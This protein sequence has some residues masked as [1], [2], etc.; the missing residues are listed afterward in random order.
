MNI[1]AYTTIVRIRSMNMKIDWSE[2]YKRDSSQSIGTGFFIDDKGFILTCSHVVE[3]AVKLL[4]TIP[5]NGNQEFETEVVCIHPELDI[6]LLKTNFKNKDFLKL[7]DSDT[8]Q[9]GQD[10]IALGYPLGQT[11]IKFTKGIVSGLQNSMIQTDTPLNPGNSGGPLL[12]NQGEVIGINTSAIVTAE[13][14]G[15][16]TPIY[17][18]KQLQK[19]FHK[20]SILYLPKMGII[21]ENTTD[22][23][24]DFFDLNSKCDSGVYIKKVFK[25]D[26]NSKS[27]LEEKDIICQFDQ[28]KLDNKGE[29]TVSWS[30]ENVPLR[31]LIKRFKPG[32]KVDITFWNHKTNKYFTEAFKLKG[33]ND[34]FKI[35]NYYPLY[36]KVEYE[37]FAGCIFMNLTNNHLENYE[38]KVSNDILSFVKREKQKEDVLIITH[39]FPSSYTGKELI[40]SPNSVISKVNNK[41]VSNL[42][43]LAKAFRSTIKKGNKE[44]I[45]IELSN[46][47][48]MIYDLEKLLM[49]EIASSKMYNY[50]VTPIGQYFIKKYL[51]K[52]KNKNLILKSKK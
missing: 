26:T 43:N 9:N 50:E 5:S 6:A 7:G 12:N 8:I 4:I 3:H 49:E 48:L 22:T 47:S 51:S 32:Q 21:L 10:V 24:K 45:T 29:S 30:K 13:N 14:V 31:H 25:K 23:T 11:K 40:F 16:A 44:Y 46:N 38:G 1:N 33:T 28:Y 17:F 41:K 15:Y 52:S 18:Y 19:E 35:R 20:K 36:E 2:P 34:I 37:I 42:D 27:K 39:I